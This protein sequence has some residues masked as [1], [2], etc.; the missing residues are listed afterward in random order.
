[1]T[2]KCWVITV[3]EDN[4]IVDTISNYLIITCHTKGGVMMNCVKH[5]F[6][7]TVI[8]MHVIL[9]RTMADIP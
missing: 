5:I 6:N 8:W 1:M 4:K 3:F 2:N 7:D 9:N